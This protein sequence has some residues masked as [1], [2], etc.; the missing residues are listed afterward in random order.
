M[1]LIN[2]VAAGATL[3]TLL[4]LAT[5]AAAQTTLTPF[6]GVTFGGETEE[7][8]FVYGAVIGFGSGVGLDI[9]FGYAPN[10]FGDEDPFG[11]LDG[12]LNITTLMFNLRVGGTRGAGASPFVSGGV[13]LMRGRVTSPGDLFDDVTRNDFALNV[14]GGLQALFNDHIGL[15][16][17]VR[18]FRSLEDEGDDGFLLDPRDFDLGSFDYWRATIGVSFQF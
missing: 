15:R 10:F 6:T 5:P 4:T 16:G 12:E 18:Y 17:D 1:S 2:R 7:N 9:D 13:G 8:R 14:G 11:D 3:M